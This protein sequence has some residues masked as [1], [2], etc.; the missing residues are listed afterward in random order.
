MQR[1]RRSGPTRSQLVGDLE[2][3]DRASRHLSPGEASSCRSSSSSARVVVHAERRACRSSCTCSSTTQRSPSMRS[4]DARPGR[5]TSRLA[6]VAARG[7]SCPVVRRGRGDARGVGACVIGSLSAPRRRSPDLATV[8][9]P[10]DERPSLG[11]EALDDPAVALAAEA[12]A[13]VEA[14]GA[15]LPELDGLGDDADAAPVLGARDDVAAA[16]RRA[17]RGARSSS[18]RDATTSDCGLTAADSC[19]PRGR[20]RK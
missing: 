2:Q 4:S 1:A 12:Q 10:S 5:R 19:E 6:G 3:L 9:A 13:V 11:R 18:S 16:A 20:A 14:V 8:P 17:R 7:G 15:A